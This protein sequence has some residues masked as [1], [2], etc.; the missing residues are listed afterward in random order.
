MNCFLHFGK[1]IT[2]RENILFFSYGLLDKIPSAPYANYNITIKKIV[3]LTIFIF[4]LNL[5]TYNSFDPANNIELINFLQHIFNKKQKLHNC[6]N[7][8][9]IYY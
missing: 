1:G 8:F 7:I 6:E 9:F 4:L 5:F 2:F 3:S